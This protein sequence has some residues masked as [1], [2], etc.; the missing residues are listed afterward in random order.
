MLGKYKEKNVC[1][2]I[3]DDSNNCDKTINSKFQTH[4]TLKVVY[5]VAQILN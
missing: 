2:K 4:G 5:D 1:I 3:D